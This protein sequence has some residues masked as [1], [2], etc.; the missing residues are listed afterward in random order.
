[1]SCL[2]CKLIEPQLGAVLQLH[3]CL[4]P[5]ALIPASAVSPVVHD[6]GDL[7]RATQRHID[8]L[9]RVSGADHFCREQAV[10]TGAHVETDRAC[11]AIHVSIQP[12]DR[13]QALPGRRQGD[14][15]LAGGVHADPSVVDAIAQ[16]Q[17]AAGG[18][19]VDLGIAWSLLRN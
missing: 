7:P 14:A 18:A 4:S 6:Q 10:L 16:A 15:Q 11:G 13:T 9:R 2:T 1:V 12:D 3:P 19:A 8:R 5:V 17:G